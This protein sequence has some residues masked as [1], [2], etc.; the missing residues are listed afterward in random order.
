MKR[1]QKNNF[2]IGKY[3]LCYVYLSDSKLENE[4]YNISNG[5][6]FETKLLKSSS[7]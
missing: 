5:Y 7:D 4:W 3:S 6:L 1:T 2:V